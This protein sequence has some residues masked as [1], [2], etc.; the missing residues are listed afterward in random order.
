MLIGID[1]SRAVTDLRTGTENYSLYLIRALLEEDSQHRYRLYASRTPADDLFPHCDRVEW[2]VM[3][4]PRL[5]THLRLSAEMMLRPPDL[6]FVPAHVLPIIHPKRSVVTIHDLGYLK[7]P[8]THARFSRYYLDWSTRFNAGH[9]CRIVVDS[10]AT[11]ADLTAYYGISPDKMVVAYPS[12]TEDLTPIR[13]PARLEAVRSRYNA[14]RHYF[15]YVGT[16]HPRKNLGTLV[17]AFAGLTAR[18]AVGPDVKLILAGKRGWL[19]DQIAHQVQEAAQGNRIVLPGYVPSEDLGALLS[20]AIAFVLPSR[21][22]GFGLP[23][24]EAM[25]CETPV[26]CSNASSLPEVAG[27]AAMLIDP[28]DVEGLAQ[29][30]ARLYR[31]PELR[32]ELVARGQE[33]VSEFSWRRCARAVLGAFEQALQDGREATVDA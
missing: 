22:E 19:Y 6:L 4:F 26:I 15:L 11:Q 7:Y 9:A 25:A 3:P 1:A 31:E 14:G 18:G 12:A 33:R 16:L 2:R 21:Y 10:R 30:M 23:I 5:W 32:R 28:D 20:G 27:D 13:D 24:L 8:E 29:A 17:R